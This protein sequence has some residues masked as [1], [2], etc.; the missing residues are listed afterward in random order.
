MDKKLYKKRYKVF[1]EVLKNERKF[2]NISQERLAEE[3]K[4]KQS[5]VS[6]I[7][8]GKR[9]LDLIKL[10]E[11]CDVMGITLTDFVFRMEGKL[12][13]EGLLSKER[14]KEFLQWFEIYNKYYNI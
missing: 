11:Y 10:L 14:E 3:L 13:G 8:K 5:W 2:H 6:K 7:E 4:V 9:R 1:C 12:K